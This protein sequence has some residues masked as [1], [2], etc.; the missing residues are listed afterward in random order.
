MD[1]SECWKQFIPYAS[2]SLWSCTKAETTHP[3][4]ITRG[5]CVKQKLFRKTNSKRSYHYFPPINGRFIFWSFTGMLQKSW[6]GVGSYLLRSFT[7][8]VSGMFPDGLTVC[9]FRLFLVL[10]N[11]STA[12]VGKISLHINQHVCYNILLTWEIL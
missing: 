11:W 2:K 10:Q 4:I 3:I 7:F 8:T 9:K 6:R 1:Y 5:I 12:T